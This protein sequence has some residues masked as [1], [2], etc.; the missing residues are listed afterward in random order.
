VK[1]KH[2]AGHDYAL[3]LECEAPLAE[4]IVERLRAEGIA[5][6]TFS[7]YYDLAGII[8]EGG[9][10]VGVW[11]PVAAEAEARRLLEGEDGDARD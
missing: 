8:A 5:A 1:R 7:P 2:Y 11:V 6:R 10:R 4:G 9:G 3:L